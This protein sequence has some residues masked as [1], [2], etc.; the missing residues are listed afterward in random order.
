MTAGDQDFLHSS[1]NAWVVLDCC[2]VAVL[3]LA[4]AI[5][6]RSARA[7]AAHIGARFSTTTD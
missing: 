6:N 7:A 1:G 2:G 3:L 4:D 5:T